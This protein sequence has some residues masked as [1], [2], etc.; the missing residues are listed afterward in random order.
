VFGEI[1]L[2]PTHFFTVLVGG[3]GYQRDVFL[4]YP[5][6]HMWIFGPDHEF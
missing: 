5:P 6:P 3:F 1:S 2:K 4:A